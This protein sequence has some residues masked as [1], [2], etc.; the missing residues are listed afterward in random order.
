MVKHRLESEGISAHVHG[1]M[2]QGA[3]GE[4]PPIGGHIKVMVLDD[5]LEQAL[6][7]IADADEL[8]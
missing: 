5:D 1:E 8:S 6:T 3:I 7:V 2:L 4:L